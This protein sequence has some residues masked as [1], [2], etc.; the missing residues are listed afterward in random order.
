MLVSL[1]FEVLLEI[2]VIG[3]TQNLTEYGAQIFLGML[4][5]EATHE[6]LCYFSACLR[7]GLGLQPGQEVS[8]RGQWNTI[9]VHR[10]LLIYNQI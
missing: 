7:D 6:H 4:R 2:F 8:I 9:M 5:I 1:R 3:E 10:F